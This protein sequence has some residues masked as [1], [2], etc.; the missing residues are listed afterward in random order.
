LVP[1]AAHLNVFLLFVGL[2]MEM[3]ASMVILVPIMIPLL[4]PLISTLCISA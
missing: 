1:A 2:A 4:S 3:V